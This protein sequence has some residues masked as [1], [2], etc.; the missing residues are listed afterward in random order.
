MYQLIFKNHYL[1]L[2]I[3]IQCANKYVQPKYFAMHKCLM[4]SL[5]YSTIPH[6]GIE[7]RLG[8]KQNSHSTMTLM[9]ARSTEHVQGEPIEL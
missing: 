8:E 6:D 3:S 9:C 4:K 7:R 1:L 2:S 5:S